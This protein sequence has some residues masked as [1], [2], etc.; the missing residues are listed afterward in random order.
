M[1]EVGQY[2]VARNISELSL[3]PVFAVVMLLRPAL[4]ARFSTG[5]M[6]ESAQI[7]RDSMRFSFASGVLFAGIF[8]VLG[9]NLVT[10]VFS[11][12]FESAG[13]LMVFFVGVVVLRSAGSVIL[14]ALVGA[15]RTRVYAYLTTISAIL[16]ILLNLLLIPR[17]GSRGA[18]VATVVSYCVVLSLGLREV[19]RSYRISVSLAAAFV[20]FRTILAGAAASSVVWW[21]AERPTPAWAVVLW[22]GLLTTLYFVLLYILQVSS[23]SYVSKLFTNMRKQKG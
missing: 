6:A 18:V 16:N 10:F 12:A 23:F 19:M 21:L 2:A 5:R 8:I 15:E 4:A 1:D 22:A 3:F 9:K 14:P 7:I 13:Q 17:Y 11:D 20:A